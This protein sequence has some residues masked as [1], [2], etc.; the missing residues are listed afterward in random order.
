M[1]YIERQTTAATSTKF[2]K[3]LWRP[4]AEGE[5]ISSPDNHKHVQYFNSVCRIK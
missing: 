5:I 1:N 4:C 3:S 2:D